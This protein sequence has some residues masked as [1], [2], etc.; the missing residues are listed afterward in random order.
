[1]Y[2]LQTPLLTTKPGANPSTASYTASIVKIYNT[3]NSLVRLPS[4]AIIFY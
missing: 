2:F 3:A 4:Y 1:M